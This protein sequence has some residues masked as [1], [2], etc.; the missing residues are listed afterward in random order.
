MPDLVP[1][2][3]RPAAEDTSFINYGVVLEEDPSPEM[4]LCS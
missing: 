2:K 3:D 4:V 1:R